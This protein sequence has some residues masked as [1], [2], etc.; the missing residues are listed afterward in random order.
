MSVSNCLL[1]ILKGMAIEH[2]TVL[3]HAF[4]EFYRRNMRHI[5]RSVDSK[6]L[7]NAPHLYESVGMKTIQQYR[8]Y[9]KN[10]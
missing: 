6:S 10:L 4:R 1:T 5:K 3:L 2:K 8:I 9:S 7:T